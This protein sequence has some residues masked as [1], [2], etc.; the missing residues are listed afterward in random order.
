[1][2][3]GTVGTKGLE[4]HKAVKG[5]CVHRRRGAQQGRTVDKHSEQVWVA[6]FLGPDIDGIGEEL[7]RE[8]EG[9]EVGPT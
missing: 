5:C 8:R 9:E 4:I 3:D 7:G 1:M 2:A 6:E